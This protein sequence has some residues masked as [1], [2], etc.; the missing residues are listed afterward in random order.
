M[1]APGREGFSPMLLT[2]LKSKIHRATVTE[3]DLNYTGS[4]TIDANLMD[5][6]DMHPY[7]KVQV[8]N[9][10]NGTRFETYIIEGARGSGIMCLNGPAA[11]QGLRGTS[12]SP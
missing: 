9:V 12:S 8:L 2:M 6:A 11:R 10:N 3:A 1:P 7:E 5:A 4:L